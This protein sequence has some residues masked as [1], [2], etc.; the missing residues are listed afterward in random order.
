MKKAIQILKSHPWAIICFAF[1][2]L[3]YYN[4]IVSA[5]RFRATVHHIEQGDKIAWGE[6]IIYGDI[7][8]FLI[9]IIFLVVIILNAFFRKTG[10]AF[11]LWLCLLIVVSLISL[12]KVLDN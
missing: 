12:I 6:G 5:V 1:Y 8:T 2:L 11:Y 9:G 3:L 7:L 4:T 10:Q